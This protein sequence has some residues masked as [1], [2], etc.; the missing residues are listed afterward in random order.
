MH[1][2]RVAYERR[3]DVIDTLL[4]REFELAGSVVVNVV[5]CGG[6]VRQVDPLVVTQDASGYD[7]AMDLARLDRFDAPR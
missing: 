4:Y 1:L 3:G 6:R 5:E 2:L 7:D